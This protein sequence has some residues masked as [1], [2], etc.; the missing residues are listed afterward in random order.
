ME[1]QLRN[2]KLHNEDLNRSTKGLEKK[3]EELEHQVKMAKPYQQE[4]QQRIGYL[5]RVNLEL[6]RKME[7]FHRKE[8][9]FRKELEHWKNAHTKMTNDRNKFRTN[10]ETT[11]KTLEEKLIYISEL[12]A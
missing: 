7:D 10:Y 2:E 5:E 11:K 9:D 3:I 6:E 12:E 1:N 8:H 4:L